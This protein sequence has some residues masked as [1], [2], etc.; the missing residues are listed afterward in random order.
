MENL[1]VAC[2]SSFKQRLSDCIWARIIDEYAIAL[3]VIQDCLGGVHYAY[4]HEEVLPPLLEYVPLPLHESMWCQHDGDV[5]FL[6]LDAKCTVGLR[7]TFQANGLSMEIQSLG[8]H[9]PQSEPLDF[10]SWGS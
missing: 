6:M 7:T 8:R 10:Y 1:H 5:P 9:V 4:F 2:H 3:H